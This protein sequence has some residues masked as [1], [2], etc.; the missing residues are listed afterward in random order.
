[1]Q[2]AP[3]VYY[4]HIEIVNPTMSTNQRMF[5]FNINT[6]NSRANTLNVPLKIKRVRL[7]YLLVGSNFGGYY[8]PSQPSSYIF[9]RNSD[10]FSLAS[11]GRTLV[12]FKTTTAESPFLY[13]PTPTTNYPGCGAVKKNG[14]WIV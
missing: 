14:Y 1:M 13:T 2:T 6:I 10:M 4:V 9:A 5:Q 3:N 7:G 11:S 8:S 12:D